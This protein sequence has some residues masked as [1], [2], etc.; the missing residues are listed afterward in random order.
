M[1]SFSSPAIY[2]P[3]LAYVKADNAQFDGKTL[4]DLVSNK[5]LKI[6]VV[7]GEFSAIIQNNSFPNAK[8]LSSPQNTS[9]SQLIE[10][11]VQQKADITFVEKSVADEYA[12]ANPGKI[13]AL[14]V[15]PMHLGETVWAFNPED[16]NLRELFNVA[17]QKL[18]N[19]GFVDSTM[20]KYE[21]IPG[22]Y[23]RVA[24]PY[25]NPE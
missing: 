4:F 1:A 15:G 21:V 10:D 23:Y 9:V 14:D 20:Q 5:N 8:V 12:R 11:V 17:L 13:K 7:D 19:T 18:I 6:A 2:I 3:I 25:E 22:S 16:Q 24:Q